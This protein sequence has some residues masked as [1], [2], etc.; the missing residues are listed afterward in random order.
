MDILSFIPTTDVAILIGLVAA[1]ILYGALFGTALLLRVAASLPI[2]AFLYS[3]FPYTN[4]LVTYIPA[5][6]TAITSFV[7]FFLLLIL[8]VWILTRVV[9]EGFGSKRPLHLLITAAVLVGIFLAVA[10]ALLPI[11]T[12][13]EFSDSMQSFFSSPTTLFWV[14]LVGLLAL[15]TV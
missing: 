1:V 5:L 9:G 10:H 6:P 11:Q 13:H 8:C 7:I 15:F 3:A 4:S 2:A 14:T 12:I